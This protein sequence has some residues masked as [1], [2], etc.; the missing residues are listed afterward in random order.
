M[1]VLLLSMFIHCLKLAGKVDILHAN[2]S[3]PGVIAAIAARLRKRPAVV[4]LRGS[5]VSRIADSMPYR[6]IM[7][8]CLALNHRVV[9]VSE[10]MRDGLA[11]A[12]PRYSERIIFLSDGAAFKERDPRSR[13]EHPLRLVTVSNLVRLKRVDTLLYAISRL[14]GCVPLVLRV[15]GE[16]PERAALESLA[17]TLGIRDQ[18]EFVGESEPDI[19]MDHLNWADVFLFASESEGRPNAVLE[20]MAAGLPTIAADIPGVRELIDDGCGHLVPVG[21]VEAFARSIAE[22]SESP[23]IALKM[24]RTAR[25]AI[26]REDLTWPGTGRRYAAL[27]RDVC[28]H[29]SGA[30]A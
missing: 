21:D 25:A 12:F 3:M 24:G 20:A 30:F 18:V 13:L 26:E 8:A 1:P 22:F 2:W 17:D 4:T 23:D 29:H 14:A 6:L 15:V 27:Y 5:D 10:S 11:K 7:A 16:G 28:E 9:A 19:V